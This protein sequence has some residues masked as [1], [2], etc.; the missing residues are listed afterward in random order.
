MSKFNVQKS[1]ENDADV[2]WIEHE[3]KPTI[4]SLSRKI[5]APGTTLTFS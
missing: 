3:K 5:I 1:Q 2:W 4:S